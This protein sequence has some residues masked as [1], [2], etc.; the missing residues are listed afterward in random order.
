MDS[1]AEGSD[2][3]ATP[4]QSS[5]QTAV[6]SDIVAVN[7]EQQTL[8]LKHLSEAITTL[9]SPPVSPPT[10]DAITQSNASRYIASCFI[11]SASSGFILIPV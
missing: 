2:G 5:F 1:A 9:T 8:N 6:P 3:K 11:C 10:W 4:R 7:G